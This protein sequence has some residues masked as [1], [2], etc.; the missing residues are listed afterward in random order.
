MSRVSWAMSSSS[1]V[2]NNPALDL[3][4][5]GGEFHLPLREAFSQQ[6]LQTLMPRNSMLEQT[7]YRREA[8]FSPMPPV[9]KDG[10]QAAHA[11]AKPPMYFLIW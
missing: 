4:I 1:S 7:L 11:A 2:G 8:S 3:G 10:V 5:V 6:S 9:K